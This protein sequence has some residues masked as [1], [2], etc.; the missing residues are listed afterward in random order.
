ML[1]ILLCMLDAGQGKRKAKKSNTV[2]FNARRA[3]VPISARCRPDIEVNADCRSC[4][5]G[6]LYDALHFPRNR[7]K[8]S[9]IRVCLL[10]IV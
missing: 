8:I 1:A 10:L 9:M 2:T 7:I 6:M 4:S 5:N 3:E